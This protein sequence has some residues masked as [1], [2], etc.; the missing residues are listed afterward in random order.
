MKVDIW[1]DSESRH[2]PTISKFPI[3]FPRVH[4]TVQTEQMIFYLNESVEAIVEMLKKWSQ[5]QD[6][7]LS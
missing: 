6:L 7:I 4:L 5:L 1:A 3:L 2:T